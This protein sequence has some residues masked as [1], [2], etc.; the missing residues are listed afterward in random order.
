MRRKTRWLPYA[1][2]RA[3]IDA[4]LTDA[5]LECLD[6]T[7]RWLDN[8]EAL[9]TLP[10]DAEN[11]ASG[12]IDRLRRDGGTSGGTVPAVARTAENLD[13]FTEAERSGALEALRDKLPEP[14]FSGSSTNPIRAVSSTV[15]TR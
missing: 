5:L 10:D 15:T 9:G 11:T 7:A 12:L 1:T 14:G 2:G 6:Q 8:L 13:V 3:M 4:P